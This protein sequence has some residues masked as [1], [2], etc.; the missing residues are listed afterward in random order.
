MSIYLS[1]KNLNDHPYQDEVAYFRKYFGMNDIN[2]Y[3][4]KEITLGQIITCLKAYADF[5]RRGD[6]KEL[7]VS[8]AK[9]L[10]DEVD[11]QWRKKIQ[12]AIDGLDEKNF[13]PK[14]YK[15]VK[16]Q[17]QIA[18]IRLQKLL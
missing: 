8:D 7:T 15:K 6:G 4:L 13:S 12:A 2:P 11:R 14:D 16:E 17:N 3:N 9:Q 5:I 10:M 18:I 1:L